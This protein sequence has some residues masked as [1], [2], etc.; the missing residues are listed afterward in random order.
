MHPQPGLIRT[1]QQITL[2]VTALLFATFASA[3]NFGHEGG[4][5]WQA[6]EK[7]AFDKA[8][9]ENKLILINVGMEGCT[10]CNRMERVTYRNQAVIDLINKHFVAIAVDAQARPDIGERYSDWAWP[11][12][13]FLL[14]DATQVFAMA[15]NKLPRNFIPLLEDLVA[16]H[17]AKKLKA[18]PNAPYSVASKPVETELT[19]VR[20]QVRMQL[21]RALNET[22]Y[23]WGRFGINTE[24]VGPRLMHLYYRAHLY[25][26]NELRQ[27]AINISDTFFDALDPVWGGI[28]QVPIADSVTRVPERFAKLRAIPE[29]RIGNQANALIALSE[30][31]KLTGDKK[32]LDA[33]AEVDRYLVDWMQNPDG[34]WYANQKDE[35][36]GLPHNWWPQDYWLL[37][38]D[39]ERRK[40][41]IPPIDHAIYTDKNAEVISGYVK[42]FEA[43]GNKAFLQKAI[44]AADT[45]LTN[46]LQPDGWM[47]QAVLN[48]QMS[49]DQ[50]VHPHTE[51]VR[52]FLRPQAQFGHALLDLHQVTGDDKWLQPARSI[53]DAM[54]ATLY[55][56]T[57]KGFFATVPDD[58]A[59]LIPPRKPLEDNAMAASFFYDLHILT[60]DERYQSIAEATIRAVATP[61]ILAREGKMTGKTALALEQLTAAYVE[62]SVV[63]DT[64]L[65]EAQ[66]LYAAGLEANH[67]R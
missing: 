59:S 7:A 42:A 50:R 61:N 51:E 23:S 55:D 49:D 18:D 64:A 57:N 10:A 30:A 56:E 62:F 24:V 8:K 67:P 53:A 11:A 41:G 58:T 34:T 13:A 65:P 25:D 21:D 16:K 35:P 26:N 38:T 36:E 12:T 63:G 29:K 44:I 9:A 22:N 43:F 28:F 19:R 46:R 31:Y 47:R 14:P 40:Y 17:Q 48:Q 15:G 52:P 5:E 32:Y 3:V 39:E 60:K 1:L 54:L 27:L 2:L 66:S 45:L 6:W 4:I 33:V 20:D 37:K